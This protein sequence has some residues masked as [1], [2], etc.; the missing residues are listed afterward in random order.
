MPTPDHDT[1]AAD[2]HENSYLTK[3]PPGVL[4]IGGPDMV[5]VVTGSNGRRLLVADMPE[6]VYVGGALISDFR[7]MAAFGNL[8]HKLAAKHDDESG[9]RR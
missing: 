5:G 3:Q 7:D 9:H 8:M 4:S 2:A 6:G 1:L